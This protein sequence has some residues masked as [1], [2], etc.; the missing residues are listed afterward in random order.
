MAQ[1]FTQMTNPV[2]QAYRWTIWHLL[3]LEDP[4]E[5]FERFRVQFPYK[6]GSQPW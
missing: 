3:P 2:G 1:R 6:E 5:P 4:L